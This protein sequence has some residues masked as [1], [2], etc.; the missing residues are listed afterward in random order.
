MLSPILLISATLL[1]GITYGA[2]VDTDS[3]LA[4][5]GEGIHL[6]NCFAT[7]STADVVSAVAVRNDS[8]FALTCT[9]HKERTANIDAVLSQR[10][11][12]QARPQRL[13]Q[14]EL[15]LLYAI[16]PLGRRALPLHLPHRSDLLLGP[17]E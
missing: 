3:A 16:L 7:G 10:R 13:L 6:V 8:R 2:P 5:R 9:K 12:L 14:H 11:R 15:R 1:T 4:K 17:S